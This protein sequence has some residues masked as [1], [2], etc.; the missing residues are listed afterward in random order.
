MSEGQQTTDLRSRAVT[1]GFMAL[2]AILALAIPFTLDHAEANQPL[3]TAV[4]T[5]LN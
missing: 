5:L 1:I 2:L 4:W 3:T